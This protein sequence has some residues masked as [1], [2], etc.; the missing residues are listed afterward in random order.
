VVELANSTI[1]DESDN[2]ADRQTLAN[3]TTI[4]QSTQTS[5]T[6]QKYTQAESMLQRPTEKIT[7]LNKSK[8]NTEQPILQ[9]PTNKITT[10][11]KSKSKTEQPIIQWP[12]K[13]LATDHDP[14]YN[15]GR[16]RRLKTRVTELSKVNTD[17]EI[18]DEL[19]DYWSLENDKDENFIEWRKLVNES[20]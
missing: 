2:E 18:E 3:S 17:E 4:S 10:P 8:N 13:N 5:A 19:Q 11:N 14:H 1:I 16:G 9:W 15:G 7:T 12:S 20:K 6:Y